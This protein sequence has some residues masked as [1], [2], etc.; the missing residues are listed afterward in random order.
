MTTE[1]DIKFVKLITPGLIESICWIVIPGSAADG[2]RQ[3]EVT[4]TVKI[5]LDD[6]IFCV[7]KSLN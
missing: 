4:R 6:S 7:L 2:R 1:K 3:S 5:L